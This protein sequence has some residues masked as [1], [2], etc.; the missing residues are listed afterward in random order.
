MEFNGTSIM[1]LR[2]KSADASD[3]TTWLE[4]GAFD[5]IK[6]KY[7]ERLTLVIFE[8]DPN[9]P[10]ATVLEEHSFNVS[11]PEGDGEHTLELESRDQS[12][13]TKS[14]VKKECALTTF[15]FCSALF[16][17]MLPNNSARLHTTGQ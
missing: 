10:D 3:L 2:P 5:A 9:G 14:A 1:A 11:Y 15:A 8:G 13:S 4:M 16:C 12:R 6:R 7:L 17:R